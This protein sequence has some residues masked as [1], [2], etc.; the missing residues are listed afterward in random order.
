MQMRQNDFKGIRE[1]IM[2]KKRRSDST[3]FQ[4]VLKPSPDASYRNAVAILDEMIIDDIKHYAFVDIDPS[5]YTLLRQ[6]PGQR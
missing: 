1:V 5:E 3:F 6:Q 4:V 2:D